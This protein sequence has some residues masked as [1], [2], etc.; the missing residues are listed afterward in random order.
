MLTSA[1]EI[2]TSQFPGEYG[3]IDDV[4]RTVQK[5]QPDTDRKTIIWSINDLI[6][7]KKA[8][9][10]GRGIYSF[11][12]KAQ[13]LPKI[14]DQLAV[15]VKAISE[16]FKYT[17]AVIWDSLWVSEFMTLQS[18]STILSIEITAQ[19]IE[20]VSLELKQRGME[21]F[22]KNDPQGFLR[23]GRSEQ[24][25]VVGR[26]LP[27][28]SVIPFEEN[29]F[30]A[31][32]EKILVDLVSNSEIFGQYQGEELENIYKNCIGKYVVNYSTI[33]KYAAARNRK[34]QVESLLN[35]TEEYQKIKRLMGDNK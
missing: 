33:L 10:A 3:N 19:A 17:K 31:G 29:I 13:F 20:A 1:K 26:I 23:Y 21:V 6:R 5:I 8:F 4:V 34:E 27:T 24:Q 16:N 25:V 32:L 7:K 11:N 35:M 2:I 30:F 22:P 9:R 28:T 15:A 14:T 18:F 12:E